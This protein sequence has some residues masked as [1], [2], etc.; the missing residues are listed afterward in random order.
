MLYT[1]CKQSDSS[2]AASSL[3]VDEVC[4]EKSNS[5]VEKNL[6][7]KFKNHILLCDKVLYTVKWVCGILK[8]CCA[9]F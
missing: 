1:A 5:I 3:T 7:K 4:R 6:R 9:V 8:N 2:F